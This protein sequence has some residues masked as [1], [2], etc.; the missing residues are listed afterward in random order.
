MSGNSIGEGLSKPVI[1]S[2]VALKDYIAKYDPLEY[3]CHGEI[4][5]E[6]AE[7]R[8]GWR[9]LTA[10]F[11]DI[12]N[13]IN[14]DIVN[15]SHE[16]DMC[17][18][19][20]INRENSLDIISKNSE[21]CILTS[22][23]EN[24]QADVDTS[25]DFYSDSASGSCSLEKAVEMLEFDLQ[26]RLDEVA[27]TDS[28]CQNSDAGSVGFQ[29]DLEESIESFRRSLEEFTDCLD[30]LY[31]SKDEK[32][33]CPITFLELQNS[34]RM[35]YMYLNSLMD[36]VNNSCN[37]EVI[38]VDVD[39][40][41]QVIAI[42]NKPLSEA[43]NKVTNAYPDF[44]AS[45]FPIKMEFYTKTSLSNR[46]VTLLSVLLNTDKPLKYDVFSD[47]LFDKDNGENIPFVD[48]ES[49]Y[50]SP[51]D[52]HGQP[53]YWLQYFVNN[54]DVIPRIVKDVNVDPNDLFRIIEYRIQNFITFNLILHLASLGPEDFVDF[55]LFYLD[56]GPVNTKVT[57]IVIDDYNVNLIDEK[58]HY[59]FTV[60]T[61]VKDIYVEIELSGNMGYCIKY[62]ESIF[63][64][65]FVFIED[66]FSANNL[67]YNK[68][69]VT[70]FCKTLYSALL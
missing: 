8:K 5:L 64:Q 67:V 18:D 37:D 39:K 6:L 1:E 62:D 43:V 52:F 22:F 51:K 34:L 47:I 33:F 48:Q 57:Q 24:S 17:I 66:E 21:S 2:L 55:I 7:F 10:Y 59:S 42:I 53:Y 46:K 28:S 38:N 58:N 68:G 36:R 69:V 14:S 13:E 31:S 40:N 61:D 16:N 29:E 54:K 49:F 20:C 9:K 23:E 41:G 11:D 44:I 12:Y 60:K 15:K 65:E 32:G 35:I 30:H 63:R 56:V 45:I 4:L 25:E 27:D 3:D 70:D 50:I 26:R 19:E